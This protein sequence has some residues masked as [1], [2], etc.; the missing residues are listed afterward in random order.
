M[1]YR[2]AELNCV[3]I[4]GIN[5]SN[6]YKVGEPIDRDAMRAQWNAVYLYD[7][8][9]VVDCFWGTACAAD[10]MPD[11]WKEGPKPV[12]DPKTKKVTKPEDKSLAWKKE[13]RLEVD[14]HYFIP[15]PHE[16]ICTHLPDEECWQLLGDP[17]PLEEFEDQAFMRERF[18]QLEMKI[19][20][21]SYDRCILYANEGEAELVFTL[22]EERSPT[23]QFRYVLFRSNVTA[24]T[25]SKLD[26]LL[27]R[28][29]VFEH[30]EDMLHFSFRFPISGTFNLQIYGLD[31]EPSEIFGNLTGFDLICSYVLVAKEAT[32]CVPL[33]D[34]PVIGWGP[35]PV[36]EDIGLEPIS[37]KCSSILTEDGRLHIIIDG[38]EEHKLKMM[39]RNPFADEANIEKYL[40]MFWN[41]NEYVIETRLPNEGIYALKLYAK[42]PDDPNSEHKNVLNYLIKCTG[43]N[44]KN[45]PFPNI[46]QGKVGANP[47][48]EK[49]GI[50][51]A[52]HESGVIYAK[53]GFAQ[54][55]FQKVPE[56]DLA[57]ELHSN[58]TK[59]AERMRVT[60][61][62]ADKKQWFHLD[63]P[64]E[65]EYSMNVFAHK[66]GNYQDLHNSHAFLIHSE[67]RHIIEAAD[68]H[69]K[70]KNFWM[71]TKAVTAETVYTKKTPL[72]VPMPRGVENVSA[73]VEQLE[74]DKPAS[75]KNVKIITETG[76]EMFEIDLPEYGEYVMNLYQ[77]HEKIFIKNFARYH[78]YRTEAL[79]DVEDELVTMMDLIR[80]ERIKAGQDT[81]DL[82]ARQ[83]AI[84]DK[85]DNKIPR[86]YT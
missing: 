19:G 28:F 4:D 45:D 71:G 5:K 63:L 70:S 32:D 24:E 57:C 12:V 78:I 56:M 9:H 11:D 42:N 7:E 30:L 54:L 16:F 64:V 60:Q 51:C 3:V 6:A 26:M 13:H 58:N 33:P 53:E 62:Q 14:E 82:D 73:F 41:G 69:F 84:R 31:S 74:S 25:R 20:D 46:T 48:A 55:E 85:R 61:K 75:R 59:G 29:V 38:E 43:K 83:K 44:L 22:P 52:G 34:Y 81:S 86:T 79:D 76:V 77:K 68:G 36:S 37:H 27:D 49:L 72:Y 17:I 15:N 65:G 47:S 35:G 18:H 40:M 23:C 80:E 39:I 21:P 50:R 2:I 1:F 66:K 10:E 67:G 8:W